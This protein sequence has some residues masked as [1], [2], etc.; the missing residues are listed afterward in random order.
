MSDTLVRI[1]HPRMSASNPNDKPDLFIDG[2]PF[3]EVLAVAPERLGE[4]VE[5]ACVLVFPNGKRAALTPI[6]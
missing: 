3:V 1:Y 4:N 6:P 5:L 2:Q